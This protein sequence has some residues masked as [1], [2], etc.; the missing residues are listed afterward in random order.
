MTSIA[1]ILTARVNI[2]RLSSLLLDSIIPAASLT[3]NRQPLKSCR[4]QVEVSGATV[5]TGLVNVAGST[6]ET[7]SFAANGVQ[8]ST[9]DF[10]SVSGITLSGIAGG[11]I[12]VRAISKTGQF[13]NREVTIENNMP[14]RFYAQSGRIRMMRQGTEKIA[15]YK[16]MAAWNKDIQENDLLY[17]VSGIYGLTIGQITFVRKLFD[18]SGVT[19]HIEAEVAK[20]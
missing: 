11:L 14:V 7:I 5:T 12:S 3:P 2:T 20:I 9:K 19:V 1:D 16:I 13:I 15:E 10:T 6:T 4:L 18:F 8:V 17:P